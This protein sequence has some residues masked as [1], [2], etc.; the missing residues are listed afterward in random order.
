MANNTQINPF[1]IDTIGALYSDKVKIRGVSVDAVGSW[2]CVLKD[3]AGGN[4]FFQQRGSTSAFFP[5]FVFVHGVYVDT[6]TGSPTVLIYTD[7]V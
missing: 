1:K 5:V 4:I 2:T 6:L 7:G 3:V